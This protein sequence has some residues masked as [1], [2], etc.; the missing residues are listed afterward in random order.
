LVSAALS[1]AT[2]ISEIE[3]TLSD[4]L[5]KKCVTEFLGNGCRCRSCENGPCSLHFSSDH[6]AEVRS[7]CSSLTREELD[8]AILGDIRALSNFSETTND[9]TANAYKDKK[10]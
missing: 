4:E 2:Q 10:K 8:M 7:F 6:I 9:K 3:L 5:E 1:Y